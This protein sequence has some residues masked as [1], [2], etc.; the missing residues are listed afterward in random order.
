MDRP[1]LSRRRPAAG[2]RETRRHS[3][4][5]H[6]QRP[7]A[8]QTAVCMVSRLPDMNGAIVAHGCNTP[9][10]RGPGR[11]LDKPCLG[12]IGT[13]NL[14]RSSIPERDGLETSDHKAAA[15]RRPGDAG[16]RAG[17]LADRS[18]A[19]ISY[20]E[21]T[22]AVGQPRLCIIQARA[23]ADGGDRGAIWRPHNSHS[24]HSM[25]GLILR[26]LLF[27]KH[28]WMDTLPHSS[29]TARRVPSGDHDTADTGS[30]A[31]QSGFCLLLRAT[32]SALGTATGAPYLSSQDAARRPSPPPGSRQLATRRSSQHSQRGPTQQAYFRLMRSKGSPHRQ[33]RRPAT[34][35]WETR[36]A[37]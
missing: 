20:V 31:L 7:S 32:E 19:A 12:G 9:A 14:G 26:D 4:R 28:I 18:G 3:R 15:I 33:R 1:L 2:H 21:Q 36:R 8:E 5:C 17:V 35:H 29:G 10:I 24:R 30:P 23:A 27:G 6:K 34:G 16:Q 11:L 37:V 25:A 13:R 22:R